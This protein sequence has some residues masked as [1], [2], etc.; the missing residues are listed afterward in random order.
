LEIVFS[1]HPPNFTSFG[2]PELQIW[3]KFE[4]VFGLDYRTDSDFFLW[5]NFEFENGRFGSYTIHEHCRP[6]S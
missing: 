6:I 2:L 3:V 1:F 5:P 4:A